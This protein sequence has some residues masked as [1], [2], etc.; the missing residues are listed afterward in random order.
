LEQVATLLVS[1][2]PFIKKELTRTR[3]ELNPKLS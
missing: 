1:W 3:E 2:L